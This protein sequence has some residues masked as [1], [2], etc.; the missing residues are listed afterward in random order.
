[1]LICVSNQQSNL[2]ETFNTLKFGQ[3]ASTVQN[4]PRKNEGVSR[5]EYKHMFEELKKRESELKEEVTNLKKHNT[6]MENALMECLS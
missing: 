4:N 1:M 3:R 5:D 6:K 2:L